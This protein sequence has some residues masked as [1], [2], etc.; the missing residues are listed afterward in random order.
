MTEK[1]EKGEKRKSVGELSNE[2]LEKTPDTLDPI[3]LQREIQ[4]DSYEVQFMEAMD[5]SMGKY[6]RD[7][8]IVTVNQRFRLFSNVCRTYFIDRISCPTPDFDQ[9]VYRIN[10]KTGQIEF[11]WAIPDKNT[12]LDMYN[13]PLAVPE[14]QLELR[15]FVFEF[16]DGTL[17]NKAKKLNN[18]EAADLIIVN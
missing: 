16:Y 15:K 14:E 5:R 10:R 6:H 12:C 9:N 4:G 3:E 11:L 8:F 2:L 1:I 13:D 18:E 17:L 7:F